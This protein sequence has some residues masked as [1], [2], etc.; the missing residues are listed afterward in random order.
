[1]NSHIASFWSMSHPP[2]LDPPRHRGTLSIRPATLEDAYGLAD[3]LT[4]SF[5]DYG[6]FWAWVVPL[7]RLG[8][9][10]DLCHRLKQGKDHHACFVACIQEASEIVIVGTVELSVRYVKSLAIAPMKAPYIANLAVNPQYRRL[11]IARK[12]L[13]RCETQVK[14]WRYSTV[15]LH[16]LDNNE[17]AKQL[18]LGCGY[19]VK[20]TERPASAWLLGRPRRLFLQK[21]LS[22]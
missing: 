20:Y 9:Y 18:Y 22:G 8:V 11:G 13:A 2:L 17:A 10:E 7:L 5:H 14:Y 21:D 19:Q 1:M 4:Y 16:V 12:L 6:G 3:V 15:A